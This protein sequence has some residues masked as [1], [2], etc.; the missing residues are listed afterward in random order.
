LIKR[1]NVEIMNAR[2]GN[3]KLGKETLEIIKN[4]KYTSLSGKSVDLADSLDKA[5]KGTILYQ[6]D[7]NDIPEKQYTSIQPII[8]VINETTAQAAVRLL[9]LGKENIVALNF[10]SARNQ[11]GGFLSGAIAQEEDLCRASGLYACLKKKPVFYNENIL[12]DDTLYTD[13]VI[14][15]PE[16]PFFRNEHNLLLEDPFLLSILSAPAPNIRSMENVDEDIIALTFNYRAVKVL[17]IAELHGH[18]NIILGAWGCGAFGNS[19][20]MVA[21]SFKGALRLV[22]TFEHV[23]FAVYD[24]RDGQPIFNTFKAAFE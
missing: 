16:V 6:D 2:S 21:E 5:M 13:N 24:T 11:G 15:S 10:A 19:P 14:Y 7:V 12:C 20:E 9:S 22:P 8:E 4:K 17:Q 3:V 1:D 18:K 23:C